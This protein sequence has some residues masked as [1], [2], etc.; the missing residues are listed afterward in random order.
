MELALSTGFIALE[1]QEMYAIEGGNDVTYYIGYGV[2]T[3][4]ALVYDAMVVVRAL[5]TGS[6]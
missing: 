6:F 2:G 3:V 4:V 1:E 5:Y